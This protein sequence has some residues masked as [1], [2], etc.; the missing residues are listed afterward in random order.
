MANV[1]S[2]TSTS[3]LTVQAT[4]RSGEYITSSPSGLR[5]NVGSTGSGVFPSGT[6]VTLTVS[7]GRTAVWSGGCSSNGSKSRSCPV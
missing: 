1:R 6:S 2:Q 7:N 3:T 4:G 5:V